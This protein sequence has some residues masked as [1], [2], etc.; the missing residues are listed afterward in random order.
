[1]SLISDR[2]KGGVTGLLSFPFEREHT[3][4]KVLEITP[5]IYFSEEKRP[6]Y[7]NTCNQLSA[8]RRRITFAVTF[9]PCGWYELTE[10]IG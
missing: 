4:S 5:I 7:K 10:A 2:S 3:V 9:Q 6:T 1:M 8:S